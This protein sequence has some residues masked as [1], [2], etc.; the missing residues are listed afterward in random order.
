[1]RSKKNILVCPLNWGIGHATR[2]IPIINKLLEYNQNII[3][4]ADER[5][6]ALLKKEFPDL[7]FI[8]FPGYNVLYPRKG[9]MVFKILEYSLRILKDIYI[10]HK[11]LKAIIK[12]H[13]IDIVISDNRY[14]LWNND[15]FSVF[16]THQLM[17][18][19]PE[20]IKFAEPVLNI[21]IKNFIK[22][23]D[24]CW[25]PDYQGDINLSGD[26]SHKYKLPS[27]TYYIGPLSRFFLKTNKIDKTVKI[28][29]DVLFMISGPEPQRTI[30]EKIIFAQLKNSNIK[31]IVVRG[32]TE[33]RKEYN[34]NDNI[35]VFSHLKSDEMKKNIQQSGIVICRS[36]YSSVMDLVALGKKAVFVPTPGQTEQKYLAEYLFNKNLYYFI[37][38]KKFNLKNAIKQC[39]DFSGFPIEY[40]F[41]LLENRISLLLK[42]NF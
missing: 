38:Q 18:K 36:G 4:A 26:L 8:V 27:N 19:C 30:F 14:G 39:I 11:K 6:L 42:S 9:S 34:L 1:M 12:K 16:M 21:I 15:V 41:S 32:I 24:E 37:N 29:Y 35:K 13:N 28:N 40:D 23:Y 22:K 2:C 3:I 17:I 25:I 5:P 33:K 20:I 10:E 31:A 7:Q